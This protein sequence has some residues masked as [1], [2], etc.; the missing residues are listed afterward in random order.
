MK[1]KPALL[2]CSICALFTLAAF[3]GNDE[4]F[5]ALLKKITNYA[6]K[7]PVEKVHLHLDKPFYVIGDDI[8]FKAYVTEAKSGAPTQM[9][10]ILYVEL[11]DVKGTMVRRLRLPMENGVTWGD[12]VLSDSLVTG[13]YRI[14]A[15]TEWMRNEGPHAFFDQ[16]LNVIGAATRLVSATVDTSNKN[17]AQEDKTITIVFSDSTKKPLIAKE[18]KYEV[19]LD[20]KKT[21]KSTGKTDQ[22]GRLQIKS[23]SA[24]QH[25]TAQIALTGKNTVTTVIPIRKSASTADIQFLPEGGSLVE[26]LPARIGIKAI[27]PDGL[28]INVK[29]SINDSNGQQVAMFQTEHLGMGATY[30]NPTAGQTYTALVTLPDGSTTTVMLPKATKD[31]YS[32]TINALDSKKIDIKSMVSPSLIGKGE[33]YLIAL[34]NGSVAFS[35]KISSAKQ[36]SVVSINKQNFRSGI[37]QFTFLGPD[38]LPVAE[39]IVFIN[40]SGDK[41][42]L[43]AEGLKTQYLPKEN[44]EVTV[45]GTDGKT[46][47]GNF[48]VTVVNHELT[49]QNKNTNWNIL[50][51]F[52]LS[53]ELKGHIEN[54]VQYVETDDL[55]TR[56][57]IE[58]LMLTQGWRKTDWNKIKTEQFVPPTFQPEKAITISGT[59]KKNGKPLP[60]SKVS[61]SSMA[62]GIFMLDTVSDENGRFKFEG[63]VFEESRKFLIKARSETDKKNVQ[64]EIDQSVREEISPNFLIV[65]PLQEEV[66]AATPFLAL[67]QP[68]KE[69]LESSKGITLEAVNVVGRRPEEIAKHSSNFLGAGNA[70][71]VIDGNDMVNAPSLPNY[72]HSKLNRVTLKLGVPYDNGFPPKPLAVFVDGNRA[73]ESFS[74]Y[75]I[76]PYDVESI[77]VLISPAKFII[78]RGP[79]MLITTRR[80]PVPWPVVRYAPGITTYTPI[81]YYNAREFY[82][83]K[84]DVAANAKRDLLKTVYWNPNLQRDEKGEVRFTY[85][86][87]PHAG[88]YTLLIEGIGTNGTLASQTF[89]YEIR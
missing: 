17:L 29:G 49:P 25:V 89:K 47:V 63:L 30:L 24:V 66:T 51:S 13:N 50:T 83:P 26:G 43:T 28:G 38:L 15:Y 41:M 10:N 57:A 68:F 59:I 39:R 9:S 37:I 58:L 84:Y 32:M 81:G 64:I 40:N 1:L 74:L 73:D 65:E 54:P 4:P 80:G 78:Y 14:R 67:G 3:I 61:I 8:W 2:L 36:I 56:Q 18:V 87:P 7:H 55:K 6:D 76:Q 34:Q 69:Q 23:E 46:P 11:V 45:R 72:L 42:A 44:V 71:Q 22:N 5:D 52:L 62:G 77:E 12:F 75:D 48:S 33:L 53:T 85:P 35:T 60:R 88:K 79:T 19:Q 27:G 31:G 82:L 86:N 16:S 21:I 70:D 20:N